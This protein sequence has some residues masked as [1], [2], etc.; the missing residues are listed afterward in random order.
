MITKA[1]NSKLNLKCQCGKS[2]IVD[3][4]IVF[5]QRTNFLCDKCERVLIEIVDNNSYFTTKELSF[6]T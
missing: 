2:H 1:D 4:N 3:E 5:T 6:K